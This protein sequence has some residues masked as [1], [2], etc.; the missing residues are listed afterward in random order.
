MTSG[1]ATKTMCCFAT[2]AELNLVVWVQV[3]PQGLQREEF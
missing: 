2:F 1:F 3:W